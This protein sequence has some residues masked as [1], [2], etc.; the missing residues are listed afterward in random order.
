[1]AE[2]NRFSRLLKYLMSVAE[3]K[4]YTLA[5]ELQYDVSYISKWTSGQMIPSEKN[6][7]KIL[8]GISECVVN[9][10]GEEA[11]N[12]LFTNY[13]VDSIEELKLAVFDQLEAEYFYV[14]ELQDN[15]GLDVALKTVFFPEMK[16]AQYI[17][18]MRHPVLRRVSGLEV[19]GCMDLFAMEREYQFQIVEDKNKHIPKG[20]WYQEVHY[21]VLL[22][23][24]ADK[25]DYVYDVIFLV[26][27]L[28]RN[29]C[30]DLR[31]YECSQA[32]GRVMFVVKDDYAMSGMLVN[33]NY[34]MSVMV[35]ED[36][37]TC[38]A[39][40][41]N[42]MSFCNRDRL[43]FRR[44]TMNEMLSKHIYAHAMLALKQQWI[45]GHLT[46]HFLP[47]PVFEEIVEQINDRND[48]QISIE[49]LREIH[50][51]TQ[52]I[53]KESPIKILGYRTAFYNLVVDNELDFYDYKVHLTR[54]QITACIKY[55]LELCRNHSGIEIKMVS[56]R[57]TSGI[58]YCTNPCVFLNDTVS[59]LRLSGEYN[60]MFLIDRSDMREAFEKMFEKCWHTEDR[61]I[62]DREEIMTN[63]EHAMSG[64][65]EKK[66]VPTN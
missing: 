46:E 40:Y 57:L 26:N 39:L 19:V 43:L 63:I 50:C 31:L 21:S 11:R 9:G 3:I 10:C 56:G 23:I 45:I 12:K 6:E 14:K 38:H 28:E 20:K 15:T 54:T 47:E 65:V 58:D 44:I 41:R 35:S 2:K 4:N 33:E 37:E 52:K 22:N 34:C 5:Q 36:A 53:M 42:L 1:M 61:L 8:N 16:L 30:I 29:N 49:E 25:L 7:K 13:Q 48:S 66:K 51:I 24:Q 55:F 60:S 59:H 18:R 62:T 27:M 32:A 64:I 17:A